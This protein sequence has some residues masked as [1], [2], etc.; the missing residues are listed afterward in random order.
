[1]SNPVSLASI[2]AGGEARLICGGRTIAGR[3][4]K[5]VYTVRKGRI[6]VNT[7]HE[8]RKLRRIL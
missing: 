6:R 2:I 1:M 8:D 4:L 5:I 3:V 7:A